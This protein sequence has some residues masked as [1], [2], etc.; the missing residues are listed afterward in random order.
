MVAGGLLGVGLAVGGDAESQ[1][2]IIVSKA[3]AF[4][5]NMIVFTKSDFEKNCPWG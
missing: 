1:A 3:E 5:G 2:A 4:K